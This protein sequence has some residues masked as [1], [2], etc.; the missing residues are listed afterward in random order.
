MLAVREIN[1]FYQ[2][3]PVLQGIDLDI[4]QGEI[5][6]LLGAS[7]CGKTSLLRVIAGLEQ[8]DAGDVLVN[9][10]SVL[11]VPVHAR[12]FGLMFQ[13]FALFPHLNVDGN[14]TFGLKMHGIPRHAQQ[15]RLR[16][17][18]ALVGLTGFE[19]RDVTQLSGGERQR[20]ALARSLAPSPRLLMLDEPLGSLDAQLRERL[21]IE[22]RTI[23]KQAGVT[24]IYVTHDQREA[25]AIADR[26][27]V[28]NA[29]RI[30]QVGTPEVIYRH[31]ASVFVSRFLG[32][33]NVLPVRS[34]RAGIVET[35]VGE[36]A[37]PGEPAAVLLHPDG[38]S[39][40]NG[41]PGQLAV[42][43]TVVERVFSGREYQ[44]ALVLVTGERLTFTVSAHNGD[45]IP[46]V[47]DSLTVQI[48]PALVIPLVDM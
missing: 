12:D 18:L 28:M 48:D 35:A 8:P 22:L 9:G 41:T 25:F 19:E 32:L 34:H 38:F 29:G 7:G 1:L 24:A 43:G 23:I 21:V 11:D 6:C 40:A 4:P 15:E 26:V 30:Q 16:E 36:F 44:L 2:Y 46:A 13:D 27:A 20:V 42:S 3:Q 17:V 47:G 45:D 31:P 14:I 10:H 39:L 33:N 37:V 5:L